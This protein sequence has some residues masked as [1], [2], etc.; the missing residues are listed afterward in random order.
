MDWPTLRLP[1]RL[2]ETVPSAR[3]LA[4]RIPMQTTFRGLTH[5]EGVLI[6]GAAGWAEWS[7][8]LEYGPAEAVTWWRAAAEAATLGLPEPR[9]SSVEVNC[10]VPALGPEESHALVARSGCRTAK[11]KVAEPGQSFGEDRDRVEAV[12][13]A[14]PDGQVRI[15]ANGAWSVD[16]AVSHLAD[17]ASYE[18][19][20]AEQPCGSTEELAELRRALARRGIEVPIAADESIRRSGD[21]ERVV[22]LEAAD[23]AVIKV[24]PLGGVRACLELVERL[25]LPVVVSSA[26]E[27]SVGIRAGVALAAA[28]PELRY[29]CGLNTVPLLATDVA[30]SPVEATDGAIAVADLVLSEERLAQVAAPLDRQE[31]WQVR[32]EEL[33]RHL[34][35]VAA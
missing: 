32:L 30:L 14:L 34:A 33:D 26:V 25:G 11:V 18:L 24:Q 20:Y 1:Q 29:A 4:Y 15:D 17:L 22:A 2:Q 16:E 31:A 28:L 23:L 8:F 21:P 12:R 3:A 27:T 6:Q 19:E 13:E 35:E 9:R 5:R 10:T 7:P